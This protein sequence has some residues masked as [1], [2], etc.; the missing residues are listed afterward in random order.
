[1]EASDAE[2]RR[3]ITMQLVMRVKQGSPLSL[4]LFAYSWMTRKRPCGHKNELACLA[5]LV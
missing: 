4:T 2:W 5:Q 1:M 3:V